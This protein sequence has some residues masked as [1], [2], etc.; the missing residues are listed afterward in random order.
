MAQ[1]VPFQTKP[2]KRRSRLCAKTA[3]AFFITCLNKTFLGQFSV[4]SLLLLDPIGQS[5][6]LFLGQAVTVITLG[7]VEHVAVHSGGFLR[8]QGLPSKANKSKKK[9]AIPSV[10][11][12]PQQWIK[13]ALD[14][15]IMR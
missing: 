11:I 14:K 1:L 5:S 13:K 7:K 4:V 15:L 8:I 10:G 2:S 9:D 3:Y 6:F 12:T